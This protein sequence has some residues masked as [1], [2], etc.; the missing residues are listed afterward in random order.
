MKASARGGHCE[1]GSTGKLMSKLVRLTLECQEESPGANLFR[2]DLFRMWL[3]PPETSA[4]I[5]ELSP[6]L[7]SSSIQSLSPRCFV[8][9]DPSGK[10]IKVPW[11]QRENLKASAF[12]Y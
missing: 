4:Y 7:R 3:A 12:P 10:T 5:A 2:L 6:A 9:C 1:A 11:L 8:P